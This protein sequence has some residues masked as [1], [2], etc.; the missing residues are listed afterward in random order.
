MTCT[1]LRTKTRTS[2]SRK[3]CYIRSRFQIL[4]AVEQ[5]SSLFSKDKLKAR[6]THTPN[7]WSAFPAHI[8]GEL[9]YSSQPTASTCVVCSCGEGGGGRGEGLGTYS[10][11]S[12]RIQFR[13]CYKAFEL[14]NCPKTFVYDCRFPSL[15]WV[16]L[17][18]S[19]RVCFLVDTG[20][21]SCL[22]VVSCVASYLVVWPTG[23]A[24]VS[25]FGLSSVFSP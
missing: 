22:F 23:S 9:P 16:L 21:C 1:Q 11:S 4:Y 12:V 10:V 24:L 17:R 18:L 3:I 8:V 13:V 6:G 20:S 14:Y 2:I 15:W 19:R 25:G 5:F 7:P